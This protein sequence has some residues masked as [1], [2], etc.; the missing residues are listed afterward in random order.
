MALTLA[1]FGHSSQMAKHYWYAK[2]DEANVEKIP[3]SH[4]LRTFPHLGFTSSSHQ[5]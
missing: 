5:K 4:D 1:F 3:R 2:E